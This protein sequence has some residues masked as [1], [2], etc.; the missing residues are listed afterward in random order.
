MAQEKL[1]QILKQTKEVAIAY[2]ELTKRPLG[3]TGEICEIEA[4][5]IL[6]LE[7]AEARQS[8]FDAIGYSD[9]QTIKYQIKG[10]QILK[11]QFGSQRVGAI[12]IN[13]EFDVVL[14]ILIDEKFEAFA[15]YSAMRDIIVETIKSKHIDGKRQRFDMSISKFKSLS[16]LIWKK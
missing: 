10:R 9:G 7:L 8:G 12:D 14:L 5:N 13:K 4:A 3:I 15:I 6:S 2:R 1:S 16:K 11:K